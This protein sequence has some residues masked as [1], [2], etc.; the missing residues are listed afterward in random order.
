[1]IREASWDDIPQLMSYISEFH[2]A[3]PWAGEAFSPAATRTDL[4]NLISHPSACVLMHDHG[5]IG[6]QLTPLRF[7]K[8]MLA[9]E[10][11][12]W[13]KKDGLSL[14]R[15][16]ENWAADNGADLICMVSLSGSKI[17]KIYERRGYEPRE[18]FYVRH[19]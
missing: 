15:G 18:L 5:V 12:W 3:S 11:F 1:M 13:A 4:Q 9:Q 16:F 2:K 19:I 6:G 7:G 8:A 14:L 17:G 10:L